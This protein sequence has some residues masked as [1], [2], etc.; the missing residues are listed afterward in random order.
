MKTLSFFLQSYCILP[1]I[2]YN[3]AES[4]MNPFD[5]TEEILLSSENQTIYDIAAA[6]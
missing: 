6:A 2:C 1:G 4:N 5:Q 3:H